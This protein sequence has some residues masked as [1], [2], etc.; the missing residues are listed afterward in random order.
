MNWF[1]K[2]LANMTSSSIAII[3]LVVFMFVGLIS[4]NFITQKVETDLYQETL[5]QSESIAKDIEHIFSHASIYTRQ[6]SLNRD[7]IKFLKEVKSLDAIRLHENFDYVYDYLIGIQASEDIHFISWIASKE[8]NYFLDS[9][10]ITSD[11]TY[12]VTKRPWYPIAMNSEGVGFTP[13]YNEW[14]TNNIVISSIL[15]LREYGE[16]YGYVVVDIELSSIPMIVESIKTNDNDKTFI[17]NETGH[18]IYNENPEIGIEH[19]IYDE[20]DL[21]SD[22]SSMIETPSRKLYEVVYDNK[23]YY[24]VSREIESNGWYVISLI[25]QSQI[26]S[27]LVSIFRLIFS[28]MFVAFI[29]AIVSIFFI[30][31]ERTS[32]YRALVSF[33]EDIAEGDYSKNMP[34][35]YIERQDEMGEISHSFQKMIDAFRNENSLLEEK[36]EQINSVLEKQ[37]A[38]I[39]E[40]EKAASLGNLVAGVSHEINTPLGVGISTASHIEMLTQNIIKKMSTNKMSK[41]DLFHYFEHITEST[42]I[43]NSNL[44]RAARL[45][46]SFKDIAV[47][48]GSEIKESFQ[49]SKIIENVVTS[50]KNEYK[51]KRHK[52]EY[53]CD[54]TISISSYPGLFSQL[55]TNLI[56]NSIQHGF[57]NR[58]DGKIS[59]EC[60]LDGALLFIVYRDNGKGISEE[61][62]KKIFEPFYT[63]YRENGNSGLGMSIINNIITQ[64]L[65]GKIQMESVEGEYTKFTIVIPV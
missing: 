62:Q 11:E 18:Y 31:K 26:R 51:R 30:V 41:E 64:N 1:K 54:E 53:V 48:Q 58:M 65:N 44:D 46:R 21:L 55:L 50:L 61:E 56:M 49:L 36:V 32:P 10:G 40:T 28:L 42:E 45:V 8:G 63:T 23:D 20:G 17:L 9:R 34:K 5:L 14:S 57:R 38:Y 2:S 19:S 29:V 43:L 15:A 4:V 47:D 52:I 25:D 7:V 60:W 27:E 12:D 33:A 59:I 16:V 3:L 35:N 24:L 13:P 22:Y 6:M 37:Y 39:L